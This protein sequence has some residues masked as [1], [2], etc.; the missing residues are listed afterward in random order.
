M[1]DNELKAFLPKLGD[2]HAVRNFAKSSTSRESLIEKLR[3]KLGKKEKKRKNSDSDEEQRS[4]TKSTSFKKSWRKTR[5]IE[6]GWIHKD[7]HVRS[8]GGGG[9]RRVSVPKNYKKENILE[10]AKELFFPNGVSNKGEL[11]LFDFDLFDFKRNDF[12]TGLTVQETFELTELTTLRFYLVTTEKESEESTQ[13]NDTQALDTP[14]A[15][16]AY[17]YLH[18]NMLENTTEK[19][20]E[21]SAQN[22][23]LDNTVANN[24]YEYLHY[25]VLED[26]GVSYESAIR[27][28]PV[29]E[30]LPA[31]AN[32]TL[33]LSLHRGQ[34]YKELLEWFMNI[35]DYLNIFLEIEIILLNGTKEAAIDGGGVL[36]DTLSEFW[37]DFYNICCSGSNAKLPAVRHDYV[38]NKWQAIA[39][40]LHV[41]YRQI[42][43]FP[44]KLSRPFVEYCIFNTT[45]IDLVPC[46]LNYV[47]HYDADI[48]KKCLNNFA[49]V[50]NDELLEILS[51]LNCKKNVTASNIRDILQ[52][53]AHKELLQ[54]PMFIINCWHTVLKNYLSFSEIE[55]IYNNTVNNKNI[56]GIINFPIATTENEKISTFLK[57]FIRESDNT[58]L[59]KF[60]RFC[61]GADVLTG[62]QIYI[63][64]MNTTGY[65]R[66]PI[67]HTCS[68]TLELSVNYE[69]Y[70]D[71]KIELTSLLTSNIGVMDLL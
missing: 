63:S 28:A 48:L 14:V 27:D 15:N 5:F 51:V 33:K 29:I 34:V 39:K 12:N 61:T 25:N 10:K 35:E 17:E 41:G 24:A 54:K 4:I 7:V 56:L 49:E 62:E 55:N 22:N 20:R 60:L 47:G 71:F 32:T 19:E 36:R 21:E 30:I 1:E 69:D 52:E 31:P 46:L 11:R 70:N 44:I 3:R 45:T 40:I 64:F 50:D 43:Y 66:S 37:N 57:K 6:I 42:R 13:N 16:N 68:C 38:E 9:T 65:G 67:A 8:K 18:Y 2:R 53:I 58:M 26:I 59:E 23:N